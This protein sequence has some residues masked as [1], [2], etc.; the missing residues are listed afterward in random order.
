M[1]KKGAAQIA[2]ATSLEGITRTAA[3]RVAIGAF[4]TLF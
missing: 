3:R 2:G 4:L 1:W